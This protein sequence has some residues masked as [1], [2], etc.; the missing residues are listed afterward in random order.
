MIITLFVVLSLFTVV[1]QQPQLASKN[2]PFLL[3]VMVLNIQQNDKHVSMI[4]TAKDCGK[5]AYPL[6]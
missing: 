2:P 6:E 1:Y 5:S 3:I 4:Y